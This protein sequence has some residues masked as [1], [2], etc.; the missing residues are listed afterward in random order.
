MQ[1]FK[2][3]A[4]QI[5]FHWLRNLRYDSQDETYTFSVWLLPLTA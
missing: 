2:I 3:R 1:I 4:E 5:Y